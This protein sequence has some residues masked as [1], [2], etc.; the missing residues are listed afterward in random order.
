M[1]YSLVVVVSMHWGAVPT[2]SHVITHNDVSLSQCQAETT[3]WINWQNELRKKMNG[4][5]DVAVYPSCLPEGS[6]TNWWNW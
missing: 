6:G 5:G 4:K 2:Q 1:L 3:S